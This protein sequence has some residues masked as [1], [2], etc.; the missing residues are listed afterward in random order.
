M[1][2]GWTSSVR[3]RACL[4][5]RSAH[6][7]E[8]RFLLAFLLLPRAALVSFLLRGVLLTEPRLLK[9]E[10]SSLGKVICVLD[11]PSEAS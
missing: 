10:A 1:P 3:R 11:I 6:G 2:T 5:P 7:S 8:S 9:S 4:G